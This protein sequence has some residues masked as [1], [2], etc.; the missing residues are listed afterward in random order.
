MDKHPSLLSLAIH[1]RCPRCAVGNIYNPGITLD[2]AK[3]CNHCGLDLHKNDS[4]DGPAVFLIFFLGTLLVPLA[5]WM[6][7]LLAPPLWVHLV[8]W[9]AVA[10]GLTIGLLRP[11]KAFVIALQYKHRATDW[12]AQQ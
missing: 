7:S 4:A 12:D 3:T 9:T 5:L 1:Q 8:L 6:E 11:V 10:L 2:L